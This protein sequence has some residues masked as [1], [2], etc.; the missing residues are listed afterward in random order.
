[1]S[2]ALGE[3]PR[4]QPG[5]RLGR[6]HLQ[7]RIG[8]GGMAEVFL[9]RQEGPAGFARRVAIK[10]VHPDRDDPEL[11]RSLIDEAQVAAQLQHPNIVQVIDL[12]RFGDGFYLVMEYLEGLP[13]DRLMRL[14]RTREQPPDLAAVVDLGLQLLDALACAHA[15]R[16]ETGAPLRV[17]HRDV[18]PSNV[19]VD[20]LGLAKLVDF[21][22]A[23]AESLERRTATGIGKGTPAYMAP[24]Q[25]RGEQVG[26]TTD[27]FAVGVVLVELV[28]GRQLFVADNFMALIT[29]RTQGFTD[30]DRAE[31]AAVQPE[32]AAVVSRALAERPDERFEG[33]EAM[34]AALAELSSAPPRKA[35]HAWMTR[36]LGDDPAELFASAAQAGSTPT[37]VASMHEADERGGG[38]RKV[39]SDWLHSSEE[40]P[41][42]EVPATRAMLRE[43]VGPTVR[44]SASEGQPVAVSPTT[45]L[46]LVVGLLLLVI[47]AFIVLARPWR[48]E[49]DRPGPAHPDQ[50]LHVVVE[51]TP[52]P[53]ETPANTVAPSP[54][55]TVPSPTAAPVVTPSPVP[56]APTPTPE[57]APTPSQLASAETVA[58]GALSVGLLGIG[59]TVEVAGHGARPSP[60]GEIR[61]PPGVHQVRLLDRHGD[62]LKAVSIEVRSGETSR[63]AWKNSGGA[64]TRIADPEGAP[65]RVR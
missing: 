24:E 21:G 40:E 19:I 25:L 47:G 63:C 57:P 60:T 3:Q 44:V 22:I 64:L 55:P 41:P 9:A 54:S 59:G 18:K 61:L 34:A 16:D 46:V 45:R 51:V 30:D 17:V 1:M 28:L 12:D 29:R 4:P 8:A 50:T 36:V 48:S 62:L 42:A 27:L 33:A 20:G 39:G 10:F 23:R 7:G 37:R 13:L 11:L 2:L 35:M 15:A 53:P 5:M 65:C 58:T 38:T 32:L 43:P 52:T 26:A 14:A 49:P 6:Y 56:P 31:L